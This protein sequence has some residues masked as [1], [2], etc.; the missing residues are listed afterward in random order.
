MTKATC[1]DSTGALVA[2]PPAGVAS[3][4]S[5]A[6]PFPARRGMLTGA[7]A[8]LAAAPFTAHAAQI[9]TVATL[10]RDPGPDAEVIRLGAAVMANAAEI[11]RLSDVGEALPHAE[12]WRF[13][14]KNIRPLVREGWALRIRLAQMRATTLEGFRAKARIVQE[15]SNCAPSYADPD[16]D[17]AMAWSLA[18]DLLGV[19]SV[20]RGEGEGDEA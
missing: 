1:A 10:A 9:R 11:D 12:G 17:D 19:A 5:P 13:T 20:W 8:A 4:G 16:A 2:H 3:P 15:Y 6:S 7:A 14:E 18:N